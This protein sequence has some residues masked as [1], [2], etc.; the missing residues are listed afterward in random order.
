MNHRFVRIVL[1]C[2]NTLN[3][4]LPL[5]MCIPADIVTR[6]LTFYLGSNERCVHGSITVMT[7]AE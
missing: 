5:S 1:I 4:P 3:G 7:G 2:L 6:C